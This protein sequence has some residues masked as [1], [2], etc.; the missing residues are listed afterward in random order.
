MPQ[1]FVCFEQGKDFE[2]VIRTAVS[3]GG[4]SDT[5]AAMA[6]GVA[7][8]FYGVPSALAEGVRGYIKPL[9]EFTGIYI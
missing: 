1:A 4:D 9:M 5:I 8:A 6:G 7:E 3:I 2:D